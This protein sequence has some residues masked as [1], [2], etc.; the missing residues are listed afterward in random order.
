MNKV[1]LVCAA[2]SVEAK[3]CRLGITKANQSDRFEVLQTGMGL[4]KA[5]DALSKRLN[6]SSL[7]D[8]SHVISTGFAGSWTHQL[9]VGDWILGRTVEL[10]SG[11]KPIELGRLTLASKISFPFRNSRIVS[12]TRASAQGEVSQS[13]SQSNDEPALPIVVDMESYSWAEICQKHGI[14]FQVIRMVSDNPNAPLPK[15]VGTFASVFTAPSV[16]AKMRSIAQG[17]QQAAS[18]PMN[19]ARFVARGTQLPG[20]LERGWQELSAE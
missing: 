16:G 15:S 9:S 4:E 12:L 6:D 10:Q 1:I 2:T 18:E 13:P 11:S 3:A 7:P 19:L 17:V 20:L 14:P 8:V 5:R